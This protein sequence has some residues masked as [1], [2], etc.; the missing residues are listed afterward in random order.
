MTVEQAL[1][2]IALQIEGPYKWYALL[3][4]MG[5]ITALVTR[6]VFRTLKWFLIIVALVVIGLYL[7][8]QL[9]SVVNRYLPWLKIQALPQ[10]GIGII[11]TIE[12]RTAD[13]ESVP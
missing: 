7:W 6:F 12:E 5:V 8:S 3:I 13:Q 9:G 10:E 11:Q 2:F 1:Q 4:I